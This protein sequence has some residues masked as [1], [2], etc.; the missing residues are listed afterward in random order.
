MRK[1]NQITEW[2]E[3]WNDDYLKW[4]CG[5]AN[6]YGGTLYIGIND[7]GEVIG[8]K[9]A[10]KL[11]ESIPNKITQSM[12]I[13]CD[14]NLKTKKGFEYLEIKVDKY[15]MLI[16]LH[17]KS[18][19]RSGS[20]LQMIS[21]NELEKQ[22]Y[23]NRKISWDGYP[24][25]K[26][27]ITDLS[28][29][30]I[31]LF[32]EKA[33]KNN[34]LTKT[35]VSGS[36]QFLLENLTII[37]DNGAIC[38][39]GMLAFAKNPEKWVTGAYIKIGYFGKSDSDLQYYDEIHGPLI[40]QI[41]K[42]IDLI[43]T[44]Y[45]KALITYEGIQRVEQY[46][47]PKAAFRE[48]L[49]NAVVHKDYTSYNP[50]QIS[51]YPDH[52][53]IWNDGVMPKGLRTTEQLF[54]KHSSKPFNPKLANIFFM[55]GMIEAWGRGFDKIKEACDEDNATLPEYDINEDGI[56]VY[57]PACSRYKELLLG[58]SDQVSD[59]VS[60]RVSNQVGDKVDIKS[61][62]D[63]ERKI[64]S[65]CREEHSILEIMDYCGYT[66]RTYFRRTFMKP[67][68]EKGKLHL[69]NP[70]SPQSPNQRYYS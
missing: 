28:S 25:P 56:M 3:S 20:T 12:G 55:T 52:F 4:I 50:I 15:P 31:A 65:F 68:V 14:V 18:Y 41:D 17:G 33:V 69:S 2:K 5:Y 54:K 61:Q 43:Y 67:L 44:K 40:E 36:K 58:H 64:L 6:A 38:R 27:K 35:D 9:N 60:D 57:G 45:F 53:Y 10:K 30:A 7:K 42:T 19:K 21:G 66:N 59:Q 23:G 63:V 29:T 47:F 34:R 49:L 32:K 11:L 37:D 39:A 13:V 51:I 46:M 16:S 1:E 22:L 70:N 8:L 62:N 48:I 26:L 24:V